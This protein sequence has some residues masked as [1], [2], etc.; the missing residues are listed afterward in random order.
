MLILMF[1]MRFCK[2][3]G[4]CVFNLGKLL[5]FKIKGGGLSKDS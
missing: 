4:F 5:P 1:D 3:L 2:R